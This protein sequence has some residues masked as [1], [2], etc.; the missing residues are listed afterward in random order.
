MTVR[1]D[2]QYRVNLYLMLCTSRT[3]VVGRGKKTRF[4]HKKIAASREGYGC[5]HILLYSQPSFYILHS[6]YK[7]IDN[8]IIWKWPNGLH[9]TSD[10][11][12]PSLN[13]AGGRIQFM[14]AYGTL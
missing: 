13:P 14:T 2:E 11:K 1:I 3:A 7:R 6:H 4:V 10:H 12:V 9:L 8:I 5:S